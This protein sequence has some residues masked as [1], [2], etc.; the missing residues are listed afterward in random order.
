MH[1]YMQYDDALHFCP[2][3]FP[4]VQII[5]LS[6]SSTTFIPLTWIRIR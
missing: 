6:P 3:L 2:L 4:R 1:S 5:F